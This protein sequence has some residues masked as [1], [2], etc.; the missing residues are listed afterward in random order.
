MFQLKIFSELFSQILAWIGIAIIVIS[1]YLFCHNENLWD[2]NNQIN[3]NKI[4]QFGD[5]IGG[6]VGSIWALAGMILFYIALT[7]QKESLQ[8]QKDDLALQKEELR[9]TR[10]VFIKQEK[11]LELQQFENSFYNLINLF[12]FIIDKMETTITQ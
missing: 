2:L 4:S 3:S 9:E 7:K 8:V 6:L 5:F 10:K 11:T 1:I 12:N